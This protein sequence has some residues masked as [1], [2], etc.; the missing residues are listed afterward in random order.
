MATGTDVI[1]LCTTMVQDKAKET[2]VDADWLAALN[3]ALRALSIVRP[4]AFSKTGTLLLAKNETKQ[5]LPVSDSRLIAVVRNMGADGLTKG[6]AISGPVPTEE[7][8]TFDPYWHSAL[9]STEIE[10]YSY[11]AE[12]NP[13]TFWVSPPA[14][15]TTDVHVELITATIPVALAVLTETIL[16]IND[17]F[18]PALRE[19]CLYIIYAQDSERTPNFVRANRH[20]TAFFN[21]LGV[22]IQNEMRIA[23]QKVD[24]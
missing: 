8:D 18:L 12:A 14:H 23:P 22:K 19:W 17:T 1:A 4:D 20:F 10:E 15:A 3:D 16:Y 13:K 24:K 21:L 7:K 9:P 2:Y 11:N 6:R 5:S